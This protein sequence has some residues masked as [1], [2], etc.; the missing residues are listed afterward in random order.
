MAYK[1]RRRTA[2]GLVLAI[3]AG[4]AANL[5]AQPTTDHGQ[6]SGMMGGGPGVAGGPSMMGGM[7]GGPGM[8]GAHLFENHCAVCHK[9]DGS[10]GIKSGTL[11]SPDLR[12]PALEQTYHKSDALLRR[13]ILDGKNEE[14]APLDPVMP[15]WRGR[16]SRREVDSII[17]FL[18][19]LHQ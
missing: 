1:P 9:S 8:M 5:G 3:G 17:A 19:A 11:I 6:S 10:G 7:G 15:H 13:A 14:G 12:A 16:L 2:L 18:K 4:F